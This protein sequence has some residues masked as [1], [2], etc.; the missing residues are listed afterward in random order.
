MTKMLMFTDS[1]GSLLFRVFFF[2]K[3]ETQLFLKEDIISFEKKL[4]C[5]FF[6][7]F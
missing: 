3:A 2:V 1:L 7:T 6:F 4:G 5:H